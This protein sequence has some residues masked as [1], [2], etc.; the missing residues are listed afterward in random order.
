MSASL[1]AQKPR[2]TGQLSHARR[3]SCR[4]LEVPYRGLVTALDVERAI[5]TVFRMEAAR[6]IAGLTRVVRDVGLAEELAQDA[7]VRRSN[8][9]RARECQTT[10]R[11]A[12]DDRQAARAR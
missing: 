3:G 10:G 9:G 1:A 8:I 12:D 2:K 6:L 11:L 7:L 5:H 4:L